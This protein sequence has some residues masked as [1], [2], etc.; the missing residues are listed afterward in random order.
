M[1][2]IGNLRDEGGFV[3]ATAIIIMSLMLVLGLVVL[4]VVDVQSRQTGHE[5]GG[6]TAFNLAE[7]ALD[8]EAIQIQTT[9]PATTP[10]WAVCN[11]ASTPSTGCPGTSLT[12]AFS[13]TYAGPE[14]S[15]PVWTVQ[16]LDDS[17]GAS[18]YTDA[19]AG[20]A[21][22]YDANSDN[23]LWIRAQA[24]IGGQTRIAVAQMVRQLQVVAL[25]HNVITAGAVSTSNNGNKVIINATDP[26]TGLSGAVALRCA[27]AA[28]PDTSNP[29]AGWV[30]SQGQLSP[31]SN[32]VASYVDPNA[33][34]ATLSG[35]TLTSLK[36]IAVAAS[37]YYPAGTCP[38]QSQ[39]GTM[40]VENANCTYTGW[41]PSG[42]PSPPSG[43]PSTLIFAAGTLTFSGN[44]GFYGI[45]Y[46]ANGQSAVGAS[47]AC[48]TAQE[49]GPVVNI[50]G[51][52]TITGAIF[53]DRCGTVSAGSSANNIVF[54]S[55][56]F[57]GVQA[58]AP[59]SLAKN[60][61]RIVPNP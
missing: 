35:A 61:F 18:Y 31:A 12:T 53:V 51:T 3:L 1:T 41:T 28:T 7:S 26:A 8:A 20:T 54:S 25:P 30:A 4:Q 59:P 49:N 13:S 15:S 46:M 11:Q 10:G 56:A 45:I 17:G 33:G 27:T 6:E 58:Y 37:T 23:K 34:N 50:L 47:G 38:P 48:T 44:S 5:L 60:T 22:H 32:Y 16:V 14:L 57:S 24:T 19:I 9:W 2:R 43:T 55:V 29:C 42:T 36:Q 52:G 39:T 21:A 40:Y